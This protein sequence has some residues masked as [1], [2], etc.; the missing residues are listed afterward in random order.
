MEQYAYLFK[1][2]MFNFILNVQYSGIGYAYPR[3]FVSI[4][5]GTYQ[6][7]DLTLQTVFGMTED[8]WN[9]WIDGTEIHLDTIDEVRDTC[10][11]YGID[12]DGFEKCFLGTDD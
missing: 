8:D 7:W 1:I 12:W 11:M 3:I 4:P 2:G 5:G 9:S 10:H 6:N